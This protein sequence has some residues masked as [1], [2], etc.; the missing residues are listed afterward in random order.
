M[1][2]M[3]KAYKSYKLNPFQESSW[4][5]GEKNEGLDVIVKVLMFLGSLF[6]LAVIVIGGYAFIAST[7]LKQELSSLSVGDYLWFG[8]VAFIFGGGLLLAL[9][10]NLKG[11]SPK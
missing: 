7:D 1:Q 8:L 2:P 11:R 5:E 9:F 4:E 6:F 10:D 3:K